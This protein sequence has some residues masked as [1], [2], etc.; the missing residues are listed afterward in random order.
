[1]VADGAAPLPSSGAAG[2]AEHDVVRFDDAILLAVVYDNRP[3]SGA[4]PLY[5]GVPI[6]DGGGA[7]PPLHD[8]HLVHIRPAKGGD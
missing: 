3:M 7:T 4:R 8:L 5:D 1:M 6:L 2:Q